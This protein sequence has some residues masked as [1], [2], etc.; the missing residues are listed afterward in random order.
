MNSMASC[1]LS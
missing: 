1:L